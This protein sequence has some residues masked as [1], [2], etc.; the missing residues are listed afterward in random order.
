MDS[1]KKIKSSPNECSWNVR[2]VC[3]FP[4][5]SYWCIWWLCICMRP[6]CKIRVAITEIMGLQKEALFWADMV[7]R[8]SDSR[9][10]SL[11]SHCEHLLT[12]LY[13]L[14]HLFHSVHRSNSRVAV[15]LL[16]PNY[17][18]EAKKKKKRHTDTNSFQ[19]N[20]EQKRHAKRL[21]HIQNWSWTVTSHI[22][23]NKIK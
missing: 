11:W 7:R 9:N 22:E 19:F 16:I 6:I 18:L 5:E 13:I 4:P 8:S 17:Y 15:V 14:K 12:R 21:T 10:N 1:C 20:V 2:S 3:V 23:K